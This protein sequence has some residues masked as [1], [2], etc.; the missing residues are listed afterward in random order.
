MDTQH[1]INQTAMTLSVG[2]QTPK[3]D[4]GDVLSSTVA[5]IVGAGGALA[6]GLSNG[7]PIISAAVSSMGAVVGSVAQ[8]I[9]AVGGTNALPTVNAIAGAT[10]A[11]TVATG[12]GDSWDLLRAQD[13]QSRE[14]LALQ[15]E[16]QR[17]SREF[18]A[19]SNILKVRHDSAKAAINNIR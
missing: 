17:E 18:N 9:S 10:T 6:S 14:Y 3:N 11:T 2:R 5:G 13:S 1:R 12:K 8:G 7:S 19:V 16:M 4:F 15:N